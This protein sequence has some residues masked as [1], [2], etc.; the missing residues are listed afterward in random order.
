[1]LHIAP[2]LLEDWLREYYF[3]T[4]V[5]IGSS[6]VENISLGDLRAITGLDQET[7]DLVTFNDSP[8]CGAD[9]L[10]KAIAERWGDG[11]PERVMATH[12]SSEAI[13]LIM[14]ALLQEGD[15]VIILDPC[16]HSL[17]RLAESTGC[18]IRSWK[19][20]FEQGYKADFDELRELVN[21]RTRMIVVNFPHNPT[22][23]SITAEEQAELIRL[24]GSVG[25]Y[26][27][28]DAAFADLTHG[29]AP[30]PDAT[31]LY[32]RAISLGTLSKAYGLA[33]LRVGWCFASPDLLAR[34]YHLRDYTTLYLSPLVE[35]LAQRAIENG[36]SILNMRLPQVRANLRILGEWMAQ[37]ENIAEWVPPR[38]GVTAFIRLPHIADTDELC[39]SLAKDFG[40]LLVPGSCF[41]QPQHVRLG[42]G[43]P[44]SEFKEGLSRLSEALCRTHAACV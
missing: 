34:F 6:G 17:S 7:L 29:T 40:V 27:V 14:N 12:G 38:G 43:G 15:E 16:Y 3:T 41:Y 33:G 5:D 36:D 42:F 4:S 23:T 24:A 8:S 21:P 35:L 37:H 11:N 28:W 32:E 39:H 26:L 22:G 19:L 44:T 9:G 31:L 2:A 25:A 18:R 20:S 10:R 30:L 1:M 13:F